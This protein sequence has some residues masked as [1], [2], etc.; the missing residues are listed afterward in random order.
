MSAK[1]KVSSLASFQQKNVNSHRIL[2]Q[3][4]D[5]VNVAQD[6]ERLDN[7]PERLHVE[8]RALDFLVLLRDE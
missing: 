4:G 3:Q 5:F 2:N 1:P 8:H 7:L 6:E